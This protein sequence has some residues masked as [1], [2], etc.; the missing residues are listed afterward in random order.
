M[1]S[2]LEVEGIASH[3]FITCTNQMFKIIY[4]EKVQRLL[5][6]GKEKRVL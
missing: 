4:F 6:Q 5:L 1:K 3:D 2:V